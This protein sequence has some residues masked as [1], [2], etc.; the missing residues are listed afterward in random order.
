MQA[1]SARYEQSKA[2]SAEFT[3]LV[4]GH[5]GRHDNSFNPVNFAVC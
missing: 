4:L 5:L 3:R 2:Q 1:T